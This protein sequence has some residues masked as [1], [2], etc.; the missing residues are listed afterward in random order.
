M[1]DKTEYINSFWCSKVPNFLAEVCKD[2][3]LSVDTLTHMI[4]DKILGFS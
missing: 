2:E 3:R 1:L 4:N